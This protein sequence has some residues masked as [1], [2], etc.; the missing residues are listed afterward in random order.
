MVDEKRLTSEKEYLEKVK[1]NILGEIKKIEIEMVEI[2][3]RYVKRYSDVAGGDEDLIQTLLRNAEHRKEKLVRMLN[4]CYFGEF[5][6]TDEEEKKR[7]V[8]YIGKTSVFDEE[9]SLLVTDWRA[10]ISSLYYEQELGDVAYEANGSEFTGTMDLKSQIRIENGKLLDIIDTSIMTKDELILPYLKVAATDRMKDIVASIQQEQDKIIRMP[11]NKNIIVQGVA[12][13][14]K[15]SVAL[16]R[17]AYLLYQAKNS[18]PEQFLV[19]GPNNCFNDYT[20]NVLPDLDSEGI[21][22]I[23]FNDLLNQYK[24]KVKV[25]E[26]NENKDICS[27]KC[28]LNYKK[29]IDTFINDL[30][31]DINIEIKIDDIVVLPNS[32]IK[33]YLKSTSG[34]FKERINIAINKSTQYLKNRADDIVEKLGN[35]LKAK[36]PDQ[37]IFSKKL[38]IKN[39]LQKKTRELVKK[40]FSV[41]NYDVM[42]LYKNFVSNLEKY[43]Y[44]LKLDDLLDLEDITLKNLSKKSITTSDIPAILYLNLIIEPK[45]IRTDYLHVVVDE[46]QDYGLFHYEILKNIFTSSTFSIFGDIAQS[47]YA[48]KSV[49]NWNDLNKDVFDSKAA[50]MHLNQCYRTTKEITL[51]ANKVLGKLSLPTA[52]PVLRTGNIVKYI[53]NGSLKNEIDDLLKE[54]YSS[55]AIICKTEEEAKEIFTKT[56]SI[57]N[58]IKLVK[59]SDKTYKGGLC[60][61][62]VPSSKGLEFDAVIINDAGEENYN[63]NDITDQKKLYVGMTR[64]LHELRICYNGKLSESLEDSKE[65]IKTM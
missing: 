43:E 34:S 42:D 57:Y 6:F 53:H 49:K 33:E 44:D 30:F 38:E 55:V 50:I 58:N 10:P 12:G 27:Y 31:K 8:H 45:N 26:D 64:A 22:Q 35:E 3:K 29:A 16:H 25:I 20:S 39:L 24:L 48:Y 7:R 14:G 1:E 19:I 40:E 65:K 51:E 59:D 47:I 15:T 56:H 28:S 11:I 54:N 18:K 60:V 32:T 23:T 36:Y 63:S 13:S 17:V 9:R 46:A 5:A 62:D 61:V 2:P 41:F 52:N 37:P 4:N 21:K